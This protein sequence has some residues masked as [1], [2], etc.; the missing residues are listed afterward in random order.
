MT[1]TKANE[2]EKLIITLEGRLD[3][4][5]SPQLEEELNHCLDGVTKLEFDFAKLDYISSSGLRIL[6]ATQKKISKVGSMCIKNVNDTIM[7]VF[8]VTGFS[9]ILT[10]I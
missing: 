9:D 10:I 2:A 8:D 5:T 3:T 4:L 1:I 6:L 7:E